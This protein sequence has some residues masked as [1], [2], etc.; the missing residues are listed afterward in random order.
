MEALTAGCPLLASECIGLREVTAGSP[1][2]RVGAGDASSL[3]AGM[4][5]FMR[6]QTAIE[7]AAREYGPVAE[8]RYD[9][10]VTA[11]GLEGVFERA[12]QTG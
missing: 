5:K 11:L 9:R 8:R 12:M 2:L 4:A 7:I 6:E 3:A 10:R 1:A